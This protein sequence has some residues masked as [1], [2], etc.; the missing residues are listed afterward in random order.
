VLPPAVQR[1]LTAGF[2]VD[3]A[4][5]RWVVRPVRALARLVTAGDRDVVDAYVRGS[6]TTS[7]WAGILLR[8]TQTG[9]SSGYLT[10]LLGGAVVAIVVGVSLR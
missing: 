8:R 5:S 2:G 1:V 7:R 3:Q 10:W 9:V 6:A 4:Q